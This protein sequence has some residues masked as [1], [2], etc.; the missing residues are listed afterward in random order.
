[1]MKIK[2][3]KIQTANKLT[4]TLLKGLKSANAVLAG[5]SPHLGTQGSR[6]DDQVLQHSAVTF[7]QG[8]SINM[9]SINYL[10]GI[11]KLYF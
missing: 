1:M 11:T 9:K 7:L 6:R 4:S 3:M 2:L 10:K 8:I 5:A